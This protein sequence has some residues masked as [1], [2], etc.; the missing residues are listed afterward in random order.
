MG[1]IQELNR[2]PKRKGSPVRGQ[3]PRQEWDGKDLIRLTFREQDR[4]PGSLRYIIQAK[5]RHHDLDQDQIQFRE[6][7]GKGLSLY[8]L[9]SLPTLERDRALQKV[10]QDRGRDHEAGQNLDLLEKS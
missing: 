2:G 7:D 6:C 5:S 9:N 8:D 10:I 1:Q 4:E 3:D